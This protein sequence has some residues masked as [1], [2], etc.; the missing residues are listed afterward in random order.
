MADAN[1]ATQPGGS[2]RVGFVFLSDEEAAAVF[3]RVGVS[4]LREGRFIGEAVVVS[5][6][7][8]FAG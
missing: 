7:R 8:S 4:Y 5:Q 6:N 1:G 3:R 2:R